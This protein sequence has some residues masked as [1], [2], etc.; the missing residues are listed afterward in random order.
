[1]ASAVGN[2]ERRDF[3]FFGPLQKHLNGKR[4]ARD[5]DVKQAATSYL[6]TLET[7]FLYAGILGVVPLWDKCL[8]ASTDYSNNTNNNRIL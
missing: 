4:F 1:V 8:N 6:Q 5:V 7:D 2:R 3:Q